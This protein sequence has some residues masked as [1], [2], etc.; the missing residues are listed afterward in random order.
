M[1]IHSSRTTIFPF[2]FNLFPFLIHAALVC[3]NCIYKVGIVLHH[4]VLFNKTILIVN[5][6]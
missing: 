2:L 3:V 5:S 1:T 6:N 4:I